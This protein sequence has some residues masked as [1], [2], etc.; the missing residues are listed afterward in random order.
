MSQPSRPLHPDAL[1]NRP[2]EVGLRALVVLAHVQDGLD[3]HRLT[4]YD[5][6]LVHS[7]EV[8]GPAS[9]HPPSPVRISELRA[10]RGLIQ[11]S[12]ERLFRKGLVAK[13]YAESGVTYGPTSA[14]LA[15][16]KYLRSTYS[17]EL[18]ERAQWIGSHIHPMSTADIER[19][20]QEASGKWSYEFEGPYFTEDDL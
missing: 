4:Q 6:I 8:A 18:S 17:T 7:G 13:H 10:R 2:T 3:L 14:G 11:R 12:I 1:F 15:F 20:L 16:L 5:Y 19:V 9:L